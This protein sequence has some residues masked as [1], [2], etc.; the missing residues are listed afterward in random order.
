M[1]IQNKYD[2]G[3]TVYLKTD[4]DQNAWLVTGIKAT[5]NDL[6][7]ILSQGTREYPAYDIELSKE[8][9]VLKSVC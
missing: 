3:D 2:F 4:T 1:I 7:Y 5:P 6:I 8:K 9:D